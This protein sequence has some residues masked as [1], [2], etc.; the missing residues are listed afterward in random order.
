MV[1]PFRRVV[2]ADAF[3]CSEVFAHV[4][5]SVLGRFSSDPYAYQGAPPMPVDGGTY[6]FMSYFVLPTTSLIEYA[7][8]AK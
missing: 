1:A 3:F 2:M 7:N 5:K 6:A 8:F 4:T